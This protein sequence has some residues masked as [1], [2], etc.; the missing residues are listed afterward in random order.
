VVGRSG[1]QAVFGGGLTQ[2]SWDRDGADPVV[3]IGIVWIAV[4]WIFDKR[5]GKRPFEMR[6]A[7][8]FPDE[9]VAVGLGH[10][11]LERP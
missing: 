1:G 7:P 8:H 9:L 5:I 6:A 11:V 3:W 2:G 10:R 4:V